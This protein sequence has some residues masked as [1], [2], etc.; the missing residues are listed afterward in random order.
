LS[1]AAVILAGCSADGGGDAP[2]TRA[3][4]PDRLFVTLRGGGAPAFRVQLDCAVADRDAC[5]AVLNAVED[6]QEQDGCTPVPDAGDASVLVTGTI[7]GE[8]VRQLVTRRTTCE[9]QA[10]DRVVSGAGL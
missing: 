3:T 10:Y 7:Q 8:E 9:E 1:A 2:S 5:V 6:A 4:P